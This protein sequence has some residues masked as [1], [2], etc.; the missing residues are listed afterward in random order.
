M[1][2]K[3]PILARSPSDVM[4]LI[5]YHPKAGSSKSTHGSLVLAKPEILYLLFLKMLSF[6]YYSP[7]YTSINIRETSKYVRT[8]HE[9]NTFS[10]EIRTN[11]GRGLL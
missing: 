11:I 8:L 4:L 7:N 6:L 3:S 2:A 1:E 9:T 5:L 10:I